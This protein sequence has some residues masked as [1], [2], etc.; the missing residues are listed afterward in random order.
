MFKE[1]DQVEIQPD[2]IHLLLHL[3]ISIREEL[4]TRSRAEPSQQLDKVLQIFN[5]HALN[6]C[7]LSLSSQAK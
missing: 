4:W 6:M 2:K 5:A 7:P 1:N 3:I